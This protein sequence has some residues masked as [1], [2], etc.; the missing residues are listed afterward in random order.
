MQSENTL[1]PTEGL[2]T[3]GIQDYAVA[4]DQN[5]PDELIRQTLSRGLGDLA[6]NGALMIRTGAFTGRAPKDRF[7]VKDDLT[8][9]TINWN[10]INLPFSE[11]GFDQLYRRI[12]R[13]FKGREVW[14]RD[15]SACADPSCRIHIR[16]VTETPWA[17]LFCYNMFLRPAPGTPPPLPDWT[18]IHAPG[19][20]AIPEIHGTRQENFTLI[21]LTKKIL[22]IGGSGYTGEIKKGIFSFLNYW[23]P[24][25]KGVLGMHCSANIGRGGDTAIFFG[26]SGT[27][28][29][30]LST[31]P[32]RRLIGDDEHGWNA[33]G[34]FN[35]E[36]GCYAKCI[37]LQQEKEPEIYQAIRSGALLENTRFYPGTRTVNYS[38]VSITE[39][40]RVS[41]PLY[42][43]DGVQDPPM[44]PAPRHIFFLCCDAHG[45]LPP[46]A[47]L[48]REQAMFQ[49]LSGYTAK[50]A[51]TEMGITE[52][53]STFSS[54]Y[55]APFLP[56]H[57]MRYARML[58]DRLTAARS[59]CWL[60]NTGWT[61]GCFGTGKRMPLPCTRAMIRAALE[62]KLEKESFASTGIFRLQ[63]P[64]A[65]PGVTPELLDPRISWQDKEA[66]DQKEK[67]L[68]ESYLKNFRKFEN[69]VDPSVLSALPEL[70]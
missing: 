58:G 16:M 53:R 5:S 49:F 63:V 13:Y 50:V 30:T 39:N 10:E 52:P 61:G 23:L 66:Y 41:Y 1:S 54:C 25:R 31:D 34:I 37:D 62:G 9:D 19:C 70:V 24:L 32:D 57:P 11:K 55:G 28:K 46:I 67:S 38:D 65:C 7:I 64:S 17:N 48:S 42:H 43:L 14:V 8:A 69:K 60:V 6:D 26:L 4:H 36:G 20:R 3:L 68:A 2:S 21:H 33:S 15:G 12:T 35:F 47:R 18:V 22:I 51:G 29:T 44:G 27:G 59:R 56:L 40:T 45:V